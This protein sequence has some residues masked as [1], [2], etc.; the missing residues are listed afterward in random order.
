MD[1][2]P[3][4]GDEIKSLGG[5]AA[6][7]QVDGKQYGIPWNMGI[8][9]FWYRTDL[10]AQAGITGAPATIDDLY[11]DVDMLKAKGIA[12]IAVGGKDKWP[13]AFYYGYFATR[14]C[15]TD[16]LKTATLK[17][18]FSAPCLLKAGKDIQDLVGK[19]PFQKGFLG[20]PAQQ[21]AVSSAGLIANGR[22]AMELQGQWNGAVITSLTPD[23]K[24]LGDKLGWFPFPTVPGGAG[25]PTAQF[26]GGDGFSCSATAPPE[27]AQ[28]LK[29]LLQPDEQK[30]FGVTGAGLPSIPD[31]GSSVTDTTVT[32]V[33]KARNGASFIQ[34]YFDKALPTAV[35]NA[36]NNEVANIFAGSGSPE[37][38]GKAVA[39]SAAAQK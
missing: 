21:G 11:K 17:K 18:D 36:L 3:V 8:V 29:F 13:E 15:A 19:Q 1:L 12:P 24:S 22:A 26:G 32:P 6:G 33:L 2:T 27:C 38:I 31:A 37:A 10:F 14:E 9:G 35:G 16:V 28:F 4:I 20:S 39:D 30:K 34:L 5:T 23:K 25:D 7:W